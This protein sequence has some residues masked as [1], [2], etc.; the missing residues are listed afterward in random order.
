MEINIRIKGNRNEDKSRLLN[1]FINILEKYEGFTAI[2]KGRNRHIEW[3]IMEQLKPPHSVLDLPEELMKNPL[4]TKQI[5]NDIIKIGEKHSKEP[6]ILDTE[7]TGIHVLSPEE[8]REVKAEINNQILEEEKT[9]VGNLQNLLKV[10]K[11]YAERVLAHLR[12]L[13]IIPW[14]KYLE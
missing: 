8:R 3:V 4:I 12:K 11:Y 7:S 10:D 13:G 5:L 1:R 9:R 6:K 14:V 2:S